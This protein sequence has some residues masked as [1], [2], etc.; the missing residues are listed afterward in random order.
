M[1]ITRAEL[2]RKYQECHVHMIDE[3][4]TS[5]FYDISKQVNI[6]NSYGNTSFTQDYKFRPFWTP[7][8][9]Q[10]LVD[11]LKLHYID[12]KIHVSDDTRLTIDWTLDNVVSDVSNDTVVVNTSED[13]KNIQIKITVP[14]RI[15]T[16]SSTKK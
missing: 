5:S 2:L 14:S 7:S 13:E 16:R 10:K 3:L 12:S 6:A 1:P 15:R 8:L 11:K 9:V 4:I